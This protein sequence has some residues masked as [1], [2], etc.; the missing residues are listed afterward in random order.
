MMDDE[1]LF[2]VD[3][4]G[5]DD[6]ILVNGYSVRPHNAVL[7][8]TFISKHGDVCANYCVVSFT[9]RSLLVELVCETLKRVDD[10]QN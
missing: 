5:C 10:N 6:R 4:T 8:R 3:F 7:Q 9:A 2:E 1:D